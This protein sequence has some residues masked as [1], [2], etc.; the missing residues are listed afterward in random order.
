MEQLTLESAP[1]TDVPDE[2]GYLPGAPY[3]G[4]QFTQISTYGR[5]WVGYN[6]GGEKAGC[7]AARY[8]HVR[9]FPGV[10][11]SGKSLM[12]SVSG[13]GCWHVGMGCFYVDVYAET[14]RLKHRSREARVF[15][16]SDKCATWAEAVN[17]LRALI[18]VAEQW[19]D[20]Q[21]AHDIKDE[22]QRRNNPCVGVGQECGKHGECAVCGQPD[23]RGDRGAHGRYIAFPH[24]AKARA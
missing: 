2:R 15:S 17:R 3:P 9:D 5:L 6:L 14:V 11:T 24:V 20:G 21:N 19:M 12:P 8:S 18:L 7:E 4:G 23:V 16:S 22:A 1:L 10:D 13:N